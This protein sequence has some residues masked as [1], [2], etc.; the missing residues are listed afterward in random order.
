[1]FEDMTYEKLMSKMLANVAGSVDKR[2]GSVIWD[3]LAPAAMELSELYK[4]MDEVLRQGF[5]DTANRE[6]LILR[7]QERGLEPHSATKAAAKAEINGEVAPGARFHCGGYNWQV[8]KELSDGSYLLRSEEAGS[9]PNQTLGRLTPLEYQEDLG[10]AEIVDIIEPGADEESTE[11][12]RARYFADLSAQ[13]FGGN[14]ADYIEKAGKIAGVGAAKVEAAYNGG[15]T[16]KLVIMDSAY[17]EPTEVLLEKVQNIFDPP[18]S[19]GEGLGLAPIGHKVTVCGVCERAVDIGFSVELAA[20]YQW[21]EIEDN[22]YACI[23]EYLAE[24]AKDWASSDRIVVRVSQLESRILEILGIADI[25]DLTLDSVA[26]NL[27]LESDEY[28]VRGDV[29]AE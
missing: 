16:V 17:G 12:F 2:E 14:R 29:S 26:T 21:S 6:Y 1:M 3:A 24:L 20:G 28:P 25:A 10:S 13:S 23:D 9:G 18:E 27:V 7:A 4:A 22:V 19:S 8:E 15:G 5:A 11:N